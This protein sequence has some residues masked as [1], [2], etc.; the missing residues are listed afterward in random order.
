MTWVSLHDPPTLQIFFT[1]PR[2]VEAIS[3]EGRMRPGGGEQIVFDVLFS[4]WLHLIPFIPFTGLLI[5][6]GCLRSN[7]RT[8][9][10]RFFPRL[11]RRRRSHVGVPE[12][13]K[14][15][16]SLKLKDVRSLRYPK[17]ERI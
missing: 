16:Q 14:L 7:S 5:S 9:A 12:Q 10:G 11:C 17:G 4:G 1:P 8:W 2:A 15:R 13:L 3:L 6:Q